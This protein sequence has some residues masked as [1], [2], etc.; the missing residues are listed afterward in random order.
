MLLSNDLVIFS[1]R[2][3]NVYYSNEDITIRDN[4]IIIKQGSGS[5][6]ATFARDE[7]ETT[8]WPVHDHLRDNLDIPLSTWIK[9]LVM[10][11]ILKQNR[12]N[13]FKSFINKRCPIVMRPLLNKL[14]IAVSP[15]IYLTGVTLYRPFIAVGNLINKFSK[16]G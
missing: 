9:D 11:D 10:Y 16:K 6:G 14:M 15:T 12:F 7:D 8:A 3:S 1:S 13:M 5:D 2:F 4:V